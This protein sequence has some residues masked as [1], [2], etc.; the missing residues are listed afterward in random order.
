[1]TWGPS[2]IDRVSILADGTRDALAWSR[3]IAKNVDSSLALART[4]AE[5]TRLGDRAASLTRRADELAAA[6]AKLRKDGARTALERALASLAAER[7]GL[8]YGLAAASY[9]RSVKLSAA[10]TLPMTADVQGRPKN[11][12]DSLG[13]FETA[14]DSTARRDRDDA[15]SHVSI[16]LADHP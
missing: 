9:A 7:E 5:E 8:D 16:F 13:T 2:M 1:H 11:P 6:D 10:D 4:S 3:A 15:I 14:A 12:A